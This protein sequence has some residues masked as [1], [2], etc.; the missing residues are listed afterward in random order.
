MHGAAPTR[1]FKASHLRQRLHNLGFTQIEEGNYLDGMTTLADHL[2]SMA[3]MLQTTSWKLRESDQQATRLSQDLVLEA[4]QRTAF[5]SCLEKSARAAV[6][7]IQDIDTDLITNSGEQP[8]RTMRGHAEMTVAHFEK[9]FQAVTSRLAV[10]ESAAKKDADDLT[11][12]RADLRSEQ[13]KTTALKADLELRD[14][15][16]RSLTG[17]NQTLKRLCT[18]KDKQIEEYSAICL[19]RQEEIDCLNEDIG[20]VTRL[21]EESE[22]EGKLKLEALD[23]LC[24]DL[25]TLTKERQADQQVIE[26]LRKNL[27]EEQSERKITKQKLEE[28]EKRF[29]A[30][31]A[32]LVELESQVK[33]TLL[34]STIGFLTQDRVRQAENENK[35][36]VV[37]LTFKE[38]ELSIS[39]GKFED[40]IR[41]FA[42]KEV[43]YRD[44]IDHM[45]KRVASDQWALKALGQES[46]HMKA[47]FKELKSKLRLSREQSKQL[48]DDTE[49]ARAAIVKACCDQLHD[50]ESQTF[51]LTLENKRLG[52]EAQTSNES[53]EKLWGEFEALMEECVRLRAMQQEPL[54]TRVVAD[55]LDEY[56][57]T[58]YQ[59]EKQK[60][61]S[62]CAHLAD[63]DAYR[64]LIIDLQSSIQN[65][66]HQKPDLAQNSPCDSQAPFQNQQKRTSTQ[67]NVVK[68]DGK[69]VKP[70]N[71]EAKLVAT[72]QKTFSGGQQG[73]KTTLLSL[74]RHQRASQQRGIRQRIESIA[75]ELA[76]MKQKFVSDSPVD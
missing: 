10:L 74:E 61:Q 17:E 18:E 26:H 37:R 34:K 28:A 46:S 68:T 62:S 41:T 71:F 27:E 33:E 3:A 70:T 56:V 54:F 9:A 75:A 48:G 47:L 44:I 66:L 6:A 16:V 63:I 30:E 1:E 55:C 35:D 21:Y 32:K 2:E 8:P 23:K 76:D 19:K 64:Q 69:L 45:E 49:K 11:R 39:E 4:S 29:S 53:N 43:E 20:H 60:K 50:L 58:V 52:E 67:P 59:P 57:Q 38:K 22:A 42:R 65:Q 13:A 36:S 25:E 12:L 14:S 15:E 24:G 51:V 72:E 73:P 7:C 5:Q 31:K 40:A